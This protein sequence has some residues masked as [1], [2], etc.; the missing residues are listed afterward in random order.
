MR[1]QAQNFIATRD[2]HYAQSVVPLYDTFEN[3]SFTFFHK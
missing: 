1:Y 2:S 3:S